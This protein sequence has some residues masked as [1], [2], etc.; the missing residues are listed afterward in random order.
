M[1]VRFRT[2]LDGY[3]EVITNVP[4]KKYRFLIFPLHFLFTPARIFFLFCYSRH[5]LFFEVKDYHHSF[6]DPFSLQFLL[7]EAL[8]YLRLFVIKWKKNSGGI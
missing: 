4:C 3:F 8:N 5:L 6:L 7:V 2:H 1:L